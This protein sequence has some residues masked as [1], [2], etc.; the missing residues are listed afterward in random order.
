MPTALRLGPYRFFFY[1][2]DRAEAPH[3]HVRRDK[4]IAKYWLAP[5]RLRNYKRFARH[6]LRAI[7]KLIEENQE[8][9]M[10]AWHGYF[11]Q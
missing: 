7:E 1:A 8:F 5:P 2:S 3:V 9:L 4:C 10:E 11:D 6:E